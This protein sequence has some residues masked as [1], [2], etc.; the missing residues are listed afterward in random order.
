ML[1]QDS[2]NEIPQDLNNNGIYDFLEVLD[3]PEILSPDQSFIE[4]EPGKSATLS[5]P[6][7]ASSYYF[8]WQIKRDFE[9]WTDL[10]EDIDF[11]GVYTPKL[12]LTN[13]NKNYVGYKFRLKVEQLLSSCPVPVLT[14]SIEL[15]FQ[16]LYSKFI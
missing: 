15:V 5:Y 1:N 12:E 2:Y 7:S 6:Y 3:L 14:E 16:N 8:R 4:I 10:S 13:P 11:R 9:D